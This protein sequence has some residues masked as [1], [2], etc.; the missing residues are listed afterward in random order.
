MVRIGR[1][2]RDYRDA[3]SVN[4][5]LALW[6]FVD[7]TTFLTKAGHVGV[8]Y[9]IARRRLRRTVAS[10]AP[11]ARPPVRGRPSSARRALPRLPVPDEADGRAR[12]SRRRVDQPIANEAIQ[13]RAAYLNGR[14]ARSL[15]P[16]ALPGAAL[17][18]AARR[19]TAARRLRRPLDRRRAR[20]SAPGSRPI[21]T[22]QL[23]ET[24]LDRADRDAA[25]QGARRSRCSSAT[26]ARRACRRREA[27]RF[28]RELVNYD[29]GRR[30]RRPA[31]VR[32]ASGLLRL[33]F[34]GRLPPRPPAGR[35]PRRQGAVDEGAA[36]PDV[37]VPAAGP[38]RDSRRVHR[39]PRVAA[40]PE[41]PHAA[42]SP[43]PPP[44]LLQQ[45]RVDREL[46]LARD[47]AR[48]D[49]RRRLGEHD[50]PAAR[51]RAD[52][53]GSARPLLRQLLADAGAA[54]HRRPRASASD[55]RGDEGHGRARRQP[56]RGDLQP[57]E[58]LAQPSSPATART[59]CGGW[60]CS[61]PTS[62]T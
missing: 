2:L 20:L 42:R 41:R 5:L 28:F 56:V 19:S 29:A 14:R 21:D 31:H 37:R 44:A 54:R 34:R 33:R 8:V 23:L 53:A 43:E 48:G 35:R 13:R 1:I 25:P 45:A 40:H 50:R 58:R 62:R 4:G 55:G 24:E 38:V 11:G 10:A 16:L 39:L 30:R 49:A 46:R 7:D 26:S 9:R 60:R 51:R 15:R 6:G 47:A 52:G 12:S 3:G 57:A 59:T 18:G 61:R 32:H 36:E 22:L 27:F 17:R